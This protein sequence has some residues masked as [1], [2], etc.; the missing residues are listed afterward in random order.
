M[1]V[2]LHPRYAPKTALR[3]WIGVRPTTTAPTL[4]W[5][6]NGQTAVPTPIRPLQSARPDSLLS[7]S[8]RRVFSGIY[9]FSGLAPDTDHT[10]EVSLPGLSPSTRHSIRVRTLP[11]AIPQGPEEWLNVL[12][13]SCYHHSTSPPQV[14]QGVLFDLQ[15]EC[16]PSLSLLLG[17]QVYLDLPTLKDFPNDPVALAERFEVDYA[18]NWFDEGGYR[19]VLAAAPSVSVADDHEYWNNF[20]HASPIIQNS[21]TQAGRDAWTAAARALYTAFQAPIP[22]RLGADVEIELPPLSILMADSRS[23]RLFDRQAAFSPATLTNVGDWV[24]RNNAAGRTG[25]FVT[26]QSL[27]DE[28]AGTFSGA[29]GDR[30]LPNYGDFQTVAGHLK[31]AVA[32][33]VC[34]TG[35]VHWGRTT[36]VRDLFRASQPAMYEV[37]TSPA[38][39]VESVGIDQLSRLGGAIGGLFGPRDPWPRHSK[40]DGNPAWQG[41]QRSRFECV[42]Q[43]GHRGDQVAVL[44]FRIFGGKLQAR[45]GYFSIHPDRD[46]RT[47]TWSPPFDLAHGLVSF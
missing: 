27:F 37:I 22:D 13:V 2:V 41:D 43:H 44:S 45:I 6:L 23:H 16:K 8:P 4:A 14:L 29:T 19:H 10:V 21:W 15:K 46:Q 32:P 18:R 33:L 31:R 26:G 47:R 34:V 5:T 25:I 39:L 42:V 28:P 30:T 12:L 17:D 1:Q 3:V 20:P 7:G 38:S 9:E 24:D 40:P 35:D 11:D 36:E